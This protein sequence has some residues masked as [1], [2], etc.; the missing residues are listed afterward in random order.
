MHTFDIFDTLITRTTARPEGIFLLM[1][2]K[3]R[4]MEE[5]APY[6]RENFH[7]LR[8]GAEELARL[9]AR[10]EGREEVTLDEI[11]RA[12][13]T[14]ASLR[15]GQQEALKKLEEETEY[16][17]ILPI[18]ANIR[19][20]KQYQKQGEHIALISDMYLPPQTICGLLKKAA[21]ALT[22]IPLYVSCA[23]GKTKGS[24]GLFG[25]VKIREQASCEHWT[26]HG[27]NL[28]GDAEVPQRLG[29]TASPLPWEG[30]KEYEHPEQ[31][32]YSQLSAGASVRV[33]SE[34]V[35]TAAGETGSSFAGPIL[36]PYVRWVLEESIKRGINRLYFIAR[37]GWILYRMAERMIRVRSLPIKTAYICGSRKAWRL[38]CFDGSE[39]AFA[40][41][42][43]WSNL[44]EA[45]TLKELAA[46]FAMDV[47]TL[48][49]YLPLPFSTMGD[50]VPLHAVDR[51]NIGAFLGE[52]IGFLRAL[53]KSAEPQRHLLIRYLC[54]EVDLSDEHFAFVELSGTGYTQKSLARLMHTFYTGTIRNFYFKLDTVPGEEDCVYLNFCP[55]NIPRSYMLELLCRAP[56]GQT[57]GYREEAGRIIPVLEERGEAALSASVLEEYCRAVLSYTDSM[58]QALLKNDFMPA[59]SPTLPAKY[60]RLIASEPPRHIARFFQDMPFSGSGR[61]NTRFAPDI[62][63]REIRDIYI[64]GKGGGDWRRC[65]QGNSLDYAL[66]VTPGAAAYAEKCLHISR[67]AIGQR[68]KELYERLSGGTATALCPAAYLKGNIVIYGA[69]KVGEAYMKQAKKKGSGCTGLLWVDTR[70]HGQKKAGML[71]HPPQAIRERSCQRII[72]AVHTQ[73]AAREIRESLLSMGI[74]R[75]DIFYG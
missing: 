31:D 33:R 14:T 24:G 35:C 45:L 58:T 46:V 23:Y 34:T 12:L 60:L 11:Y 27:D 21:P 28:H 65:Y 32:A 2:E 62:T 13:A 20:L 74:R 26:H 75:E 69:G 42:L 55:G 64:F 61:K 73:K 25:V 51:K 22:G 41:L 49:Q 43:R 47:L 8:K 72:I 63:R 67:T 36:Y 48:K 30:L 57:A 16:E 68:L 29:I 39:E 19:L 53:V 18:S 15:D 59:P 70:L 54:Q 40:K 3:L 1:E 71:I 66:A 38:P 50:D 4:R 10:E 52:N 37:D 5:Y 56:H 7:D 6:L 17:N 44:D 9:Q